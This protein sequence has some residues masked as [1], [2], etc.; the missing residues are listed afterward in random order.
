MDYRYI[1]SQIYELERKWKCLCVKVDNCLGISDEGDESLVLNQK[2]EWIEN[3]S[4]GT[5][6]PAGDNTWI[7]YNSNGSFGADSNFTR[8]SSQYTV[9]KAEDGIGNHGIL[10]VANNYTVMAYNTA[11]NDGGFIVLEETFG[12]FGY[13]TS[14]TLINY[15][16]S[17]P[18]SCGWVGTDSFILPS[19]DGNA[20]DVLTTDGTGIL[21]WEKTVITGDIAFSGDGVETFY[22][23]TT[24]DIPTWASATAGS[25]DSANPF[26]ITLSG[27][28][29]GINFITP[30][31]A[32]TNN[33]VFYYQYKT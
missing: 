17:D 16:Y 7:Q 3:G 13:R 31:P 19:T 29:I 6:N 18:S 22:E 10:E 11:G 33:L 24:P 2:G 8:N 1:Q 28:G 5:T 12:R 20:G 26:F 15:F 32:G 23:I 25:T 27:T 9:I 21:T 14:A 30:P 4:G